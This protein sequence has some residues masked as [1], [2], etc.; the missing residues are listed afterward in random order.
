LRTPANPEPNLN[1]TPRTGS[2]GS[3]QSSSLE[4]N[5]TPSSVRSSAKRVPN[6]TEPNFGTSSGNPVSGGQLGGAD[7]C[8][9]EE[10]GNESDTPFPGNESV[11]DELEAGRY[12]DYSHDDDARSF[13]TSVYQLSG[14][15]LRSY[16]ARGRRKSRHLRNCSIVIAHSHQM[17]CGTSSL[18]LKVNVYQDM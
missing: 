13:A 17:E 14:P 15:E 9:R 7:V 1:R 4:V 8:G 3:V 18:P 5:R 16:R 12:S 6:R 2:R 11:L 10:T